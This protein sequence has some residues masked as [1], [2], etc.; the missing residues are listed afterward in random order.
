MGSAGYP[1]TI[2][3]CPTI[4][5]TEF[6]GG[7]KEDVGTWIALQRYLRRQNLSDSQQVDTILFSLTGHAK[8]ALGN[9]AGMDSFANAQEIF[10]SLRALYGPKSSNTQRLYNARQ[11]PD[12]P[13]TPFLSRVRRYVRE[14]GKMESAASD[15]LVLLFFLLGLR[16]EIKKKMPQDT[17][18]TT[19]AA[20]LAKAQAIEGELAA[21][22]DSKT[23]TLMTMNEPTT[24]R[25]ADVPADQSQLFQAILNRL[26]RS[27]PGGATAN[28]APNFRPAFNSNRRFGNVECFHCHKLGH[29]FRRC[30]LNSDAQRRDLE[31]KLKEG[32]LMTRPRSANLPSEALNS[33][34]ATQNPSPALQ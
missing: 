22:R 9:Y 20:A 23:D 12:E 8:E 5:L 10:D 29:T 33:S 21:K 11:S 30:R 16:P 15:E 13:V 31:R 14:M 24:S 25:V 1:A 6:T 17:T 3:L 28:E 34:G 18:A 26:D 4:K 27:Q 19:I 32:K 2:E 7:E